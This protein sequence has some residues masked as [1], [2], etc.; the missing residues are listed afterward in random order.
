MVLHIAILTATTQAQSVNM[1]PFSGFLGTNYEPTAD[2]TLSQ[3]TYIPNLPTTSIYPMMADESY[4]TMF[5]LPSIKPQGNPFLNPLLQ[6]AS[7]QHSVS[8]TRNSNYKRNLNMNPQHQQGNNRGVTLDMRGGGYKLENPRNV[9]PYKAPVAESS[10][11]NTQRYQD[12]RTFVRNPSNGRNS[13]RQGNS[14]PRSRGPTLNNP[15]YNQKFESVLPSMPPNVEFVN[16]ESVLPLHPSIY[17]PFL[18]QNKQFAS[19]FRNLNKSKPSSGGS[20][21]GSFQGSSFG[22]PKPSASRPTRNRGSPSSS[23]LSQSSLYSNFAPDFGQLSESD[24]SNSFFQQQSGG[25]PFSSQFDTSLFNQDTSFYSSFSQTPEGK[26]LLSQ[27]QSQAGAQ[28]KPS[29]F[30]SHS[31]SFANKPSQH[32][33]SNANSPIFA[34]SS[35]SSSSGGAGSQSGIPSFGSNY[36]ATSQGFGQTD[37]SSLNQS[38]NIDYQQMMA[39]YKQQMQQQPQQEIAQPQQYSASSG[40]NL[41]SQFQAQSSAPSYSP[42]QQYQFLQGQGSRFQDH[43]QTYTPE[44]ATY[45]R[46]KVAANPYQA[47]HKDI[48]SHTPIHTDQTSYTHSNFAPLETL[49]SVANNNKAVHDY[50]SYHT[51][52]HQQSPQFTVHQKVPSYLKGGLQQILPNSEEKTSMDHIVSSQGSSSKTSESSHGYMTPEQLFAP[53]HTG[54]QSEAKFG[55]P[56]AHGGSSKDSSE[57]EAAGSTPEQHTVEGN[58]LEGGGRAALHKIT[59]GY[60]PFSLEE[61]EKLKYQNDLTSKEESKENSA[62]AE[63]DERLHE[64]IQEI[65][66]LLA[67]APKNTYMVEPTDSSHSSTAT[68]KSSSEEMV[69]HKTTPSYM[70]QYAP[71][72]K[73]VTKLQPTWHAWK[74]N[75]S[76]YHLTLP[77]QKFTTSAISSTTEST[78]E[79]TTMAS[80][81]TSTTAPYI[82]VSMY[83]EPETPMCARH[84]NLT[85]CLQDTEYPKEKIKEAIE[86]NRHPLDHFLVDIS[87]SSNLVEDNSI[88]KVL[89]NS[90]PLQSTAVSYSYDGKTISPAAQAGNVSS[91]GCSSSTFY[92]K[93]LRAINT[94]GLWR[95]IVNVEF[96]ETGANYTQTVRL[97]ECSH[98]PGFVATCGTET[99]SACLQNYKLH[100][101]LAWEEHRG[102]YIDAFLLPISCF[103]GTQQSNSS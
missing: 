69:N 71:A 88:N 86:K 5:G 24:I 48:R 70:F 12:G 89:E 32:T 29:N 73:S 100:R 43:S 67:K 58:I 63:S 15:H 80:T 99:I 14:P 102:F 41:Q 75:A 77:E 6:E 46:A 59:I 26:A 4:Q 81:T 60:D 93:P 51:S 72:E 79:S 96:E 82:K 47:N 8:D 35:I 78:T 49:A 74:S 1:N 18:Q 94:A 7:I 53:E 33:Y 11:R 22:N 56:S 66:K 13:G 3:G 45:T 37:A 38:P 84:T 101:L 64:T 28:N 27:I 103:C 57:N 2:F 19:R 52:G 95:T 30:K 36:F 62:E 54:L 21:S 91:A 90:V 42:S 20:Y 40:Q 31:T 50:F 98:S 34:G 87:A 16:P 23:A 97:E 25:N 83:H 85:Y 44:S 68:T 39:Y 76:H 92:G 9:R 10:V 65:Q 17:K 55:Y 61:S